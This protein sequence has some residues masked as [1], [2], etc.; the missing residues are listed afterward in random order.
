MGKMLVVAEKP[1]VAEEYARALGGGFEKHEGYLESERYVVSWAVGHLVGLAEP[2]EYDE[3]LKRWSIKSLP[4]MPEQFRLRPD[5][6][7]RKQL[8]VLEK[9]MRRGDVDE[10]VNGC[11]AGREGELIFAYIRDWVGAEKPVRR[12][13]VSSMTREAVAEGFRRLRDGAELADLAD[14]ARSRSEADWLVGM[15]ATRAATVRAR[16]L[17]G[18]VSL[19]RVQTPTLALIVARDAEIDAFVPETYFF[20]GARFALDG[21]EARRYEGRWFDGDEERIAD[22]ERAERVATAANGAACRV[23]SVERRERRERA[24]LLYDLTSLQREASNRFGITATRTLAAAQRLYEGST[25]GALLTY[26]RTKSRY[27]PS[28]QVPHLQGIAQRLASYP[29]HRRAAEYVAGLAALPLGRVVDDAKV[30]DHHA[31]VPTGELATKALSG[32]DAR[33]YDLVVRR[34]LAVFHPDARWEDTEIVTEAGG[35]RFRTRGRRLVE[36]GWR[37]AYEE[38]AR[39]E[40]GGEAAE[41]AEGAESAEA[42]ADDRLLPRVEQGERGVCEEAVAEERQTRPPPRYSE[43]ALLSAMESAGRSIEDEELRE[44]M[45][46]SGLGTPA[47]RAETIEKLIRV[48]Y[49]ER[50]GRSLRATAKGR[51]TIGVLGESAL[52]SAELTGRWEHRLNQIERGEEP[53][54]GFM[55]DIRAFTGDLVERFRG[56]TSEDVRA[57]RAV[58]G[59]CPNGDGEIRENRMAYGCS[60]WKSAEEPGCGFVIWKTVKGRSISPGEAGELLRTGETRLLDGFK[61]RPSKGKLVLVD[62]QVQLVDEQGVRLDTPAA[63]R[64]AIATCPKCGGEIKENNRAY[65]CSSWKSKSNPGCGFVIWKSTAGHQVTPEEARELIERGRTDEIEFK[66]RKSSYRGWLVLGEDLGVSVERADG[67]PVA[68]PRKR[69]AAPEVAGPAV[70]SEEPARPAAEAA[71][72]AARRAEPA[73]A[74]AAE[75]RAA[76][77]VL[78]RPAAAAGDDALGQLLAAEGVEVVDRRGSGGAL[79]VIGGPELGGLMERLAGQGFKFVFA[80]EGGRA[81]KHRPAWWIK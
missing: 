7:G 46:E 22:R 39:D 1:S 50:M 51:Q 33:V 78:E 62:G 76:V 54:D 59:P 73:R 3:R 5:Q 55:A 44:A 64:E 75:G 52:T 27:L 80:K 24:P 58:L 9:L 53:R 81:S 65:G 17:G 23:E 18:V 38:V 2:E 43:A 69:P 74:V 42:E 37:A 21:G 72:P 30:D 6:K 60:S 32:D 10:I 35:E 61:T 25:A 67:K 13:W 36:P 8:G 12:L 41:G 56:V 26:P 34:F 20:V 29:Q 4:I 19:G 14:A 45:K 31:I 40:P 79:W 63:A 48:Q 47:T 28:D 68:A 57:Q 15:N 16:A 71:R 66:E 11:D 70:V 77:G 49:V